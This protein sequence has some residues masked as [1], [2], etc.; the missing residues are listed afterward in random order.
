MKGYEAIARALVDCGVEA[1]F[2]VIGDGNMHYVAEYVGLDRG[3]YYGAVGESGAVS[4]ADGYA[5][6]SGRAGIATTTHGP[7]ATNTITALTEAARAHSPVVLLTGEAVATRG[8][9]Q[10]IELGTLFAGTG[11]DY[12]RCLAAEQIVDDVAIATTR[13]V[14]TGTPAVLD[15]SY[16]LVHS[17]VTWAPPRFRD[18]P[19][20]PSSPSADALDE[21]VGLL[22]S[23]QRP[24]VVAG[25][26]AVLSHA[27]D[28]LVALADRLG[29]PLATTVNA[30]DYFRDHPFNLGIIGSV[31][32]EY[33]SDIVS[34]AD[35]LVFFGASM[36]RYTTL[37]GDFTRGRSV[38]QVNPDPAAVGRWEPVDVALKSDAAA[39][40]R[41]MLEMLDELGG[42]PR[43]FRVSRMGEG[44][45][46]RRPGE[47]FR[48]R[49]SHAG[50]D[51]RAVMVRLDEML[52]ADRAV[53][54]DI[55]RFVVAPW[56]YLRVQEPGDFSQM[57]AFASIGLGAFAAIGAAAAR[58]DRLT[59][60]V[61]GDGGMMM[62]IPELHTAVKYSLPLFMV[63][64]NDR[65]YGA[66]FKKLEALGYDPEFC[67][68]DWPSFAGMARALGCEAE[69]V[70]TVSELE[71]A[72]ARYA[73]TDR[74]VLIEVLIDPMI[75][76]KVP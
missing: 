31:A 16:D 70:S 33:A 17:E 26:G 66:E 15:I 32:T 1:A 76:P 55:G 57:G 73:T 36:S 12:Y 62:S 41:L 27:R 29:A 46:G 25:R 2:G 23:A 60:G 44:S 34:S 5:R 74:P 51:P 8:W 45:L 14:A 6:M 35:C 47:D 22:A 37:D 3:R 42:E 63:V 43:G 69:T 19:P 67:Y 38:I 56:R 65:A 13:A 58:P 64:L 52:P 49:S 39:T 59:V 18:H 75:D 9:P 53:V 24:V 11:A 20:T 71:S 30:K 7:G 68:N 50:L 40:A 72:V 4:M 61:A 54:S 28:D 21:A 10:R 48:D